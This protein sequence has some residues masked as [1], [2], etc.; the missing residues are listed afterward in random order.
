VDWFSI[1]TALRAPNSKKGTKTMLGNVLGDEAEGS[2]LGAILGELDGLDGEVLGA[3]A[4]AVQTAV[5]RRSGAH[6]HGNVHVERPHWRGREL[7]PG[8]NAPGE[9][10]VPMPLAAIN[11]TGPGGTG[12]W[13]ATA[14]GLVTFQGQ[15]Q[16]P[17]KGERI[18]ATSQRSGASATA[19]LLAQMFVGVDLNQ[20]T[21]QSFDVEA[22]GAPTSFDMGM[23]LMQAPPGVIFSM[24]VSLGGTPPTGTD[25]I[26]LALSIK[27]RI[28]H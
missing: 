6:H 28:I 4:Q 2:V 20:A 10:Q 14:V 27:G 22:Y 12:V 16:K 7:G 17:F 9:G 26:T 24:L 5:R 18:V 23:S 25:T 11:Q 19:L 1:V 3:V 8:I 13:S 21:I 15:L